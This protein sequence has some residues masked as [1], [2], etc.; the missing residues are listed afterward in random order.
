MGDL[1][2]R[3]L[4]LISSILASSF[5][6]GADWVYVGS[7]DS[8][9]KFYVDFD[10][11]DYDKKI[12]TVKSWYRVDKYL[13]GRYYIEQKTLAEHYC[14]SS[15]S[16]TLSAVHYH[17]NGSVGKTFEADYLTQSTR[18]FPETT[19]EYLYKVACDTPGKGLDFKDK[20]ID[21][22]DNFNEYER[23]RFAYM[24]EKM[25]NSIP[26]ALIPSLN[27]LDYDNYSD[28]SRDEK[29]EMDKIRIKNIQKF[30]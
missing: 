3:K 16:K 14:R 24:R 21:E 19:G 1:F 7:S 11:Y 28:F 6:F 26:R 5:S 27:I 12:N 10:Y 13:N 30:K 18:V 17:P 20:P 9:D 29:K 23:V 4:I 8:G 25:P 15:R 22:M 2:M